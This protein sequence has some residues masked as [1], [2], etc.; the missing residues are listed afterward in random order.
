[1]AQTRKTTKAKAPS[2]RITRVATAPK[3]PASES[4]APPRGRHNAARRSAPRLPNNA[5]SSI[6]VESPSSTVELS[7]SSPAFTQDDIPRIVDAI[8]RGMP[9]NPLA[10]LIDGDEF[11]VTMTSFEDQPAETTT[12]KTSYLYV[13]N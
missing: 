5:R 1:M 8:L 2:S 13:S 7:T 3:A 9:P 4:R 11:D 10:V 12:G 6:S